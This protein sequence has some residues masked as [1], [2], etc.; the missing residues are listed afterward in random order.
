MFPSLSETLEG[1]RRELDRAPVLSQLAARLEREPGEAGRNE[2]FDARL[3]ELK[4]E[5][6]ASLA[7]DLNISGALG[8]LFRLVREVHVALDKQELPLDSRG[9]LQEALSWFDGVLGVFSRHTEEHDEQIDDL[10][11]RRDEARASR[12]FAEADRI[13]DELTASGIQLEDTPQGTVWK[14]KLSGG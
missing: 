4:R 11:R 14:R 9:E 12:D 6:E 2:A 10:V 7:D 1:R 5:F 8:A 3:A 13:R